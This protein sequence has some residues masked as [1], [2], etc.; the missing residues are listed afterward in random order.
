MEEKQT[1]PS[2]KKPFNFKKGFIISL[3]LACVFA[4]Y[5]I[6]ASILLIDFDKERKLMTKEEFYA[7]AADDVEIPIIEINTKESKEPE[8]KTDYVDCSV[9]I[10]NTEN[11]DHLLSVKMGEAGVRLRGNS[12]MREDKKPYRIKFESKQ[13]V[14]GMPKNK[15]WV[16]L[17]DYY[18]QS[19]IRNYTAF[20]L[21]SY[22]DNLDFVPS[23]NH[24]VLIMN[25]EFR[26]L[27]L[28]SDQIDEKRVDVE[29]DVE[30][31]NIETPNDIPF[32][33]EI[34]E[35]AV[36]EGVTGV[37]NFKVNA[38]DNYAEVKYP[39]SDERPYDSD[40]NDV[41]F[42]YIEEY[43]NAVFTSLKTGKAVDVSFS[44]TDVTFEDLVDV[45]SLVDYYLLNEIMLN[46]DSGK[47]SVYVHKASGEKMKFGPIWDYDWSMATKWQ[48]PYQ[49]GEI[50]VASQIRVAKAY[51]NSLYGWFL[52]NE[53]NYNAVAER[54]DEIKENILAVSEHLKTYRSKI[55]VVATLD[56]KQWYG[57]NGLFEYDM[58]YT[59]VRLFLNDRYTFL[60]QVFDDTHEN[61]LTRIGYGN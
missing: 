41:C 40:G 36:N 6:V 46:M 48:V 38:L 56:A 8:N 15:S 25:G 47:K 20:T 11:D 28:L 45:D 27:Y 51:K 7:A 60:N 3:V 1:Q 18:D 2:E 14:L 44:T 26:G 5:S 58:Q 13:S 9:K 16:L 43:I 54:F 21:G 32:L 4:V 42:D 57:E 34:D 50:E 22:F 37:D 39:E 61:F 49:Q 12:T 24:V 33:V 19:S 59:Y 17:A 10:S 31:I 52:A 30:E 29:Q 35:Y 53:D 55:D 23:A